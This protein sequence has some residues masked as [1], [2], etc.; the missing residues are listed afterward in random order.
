VS[1]AKVAVTPER[2]M[3]SPAS[4]GPA[5]WQVCHIS[6]LRASALGSS[7]RP[8]RVG[9][10]AVRVGMS[11]PVKPASAAVSTK[12]SHSRGE[13]E[14]A[15]RVRPRQHAPSSSCA[16]SRIFRRSWASASAPP[17]S[18][19]PMRGNSA[20]RLSRPVASD[21]SVSW[22]TWMGAATSVSWLPVAETSCPA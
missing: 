20:A 15:L 2:A 17:T 14:A 19:P 21:E 7:S 10:A 13:G 22:Y 18:E 6:W 3:I 4:A 16:T 1:A 11:S 8:T 5:T 12:I 9:T